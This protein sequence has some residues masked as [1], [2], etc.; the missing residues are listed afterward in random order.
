MSSSHLT[1]AQIQFIDSLADLL[2][3]W[4]LSAHAARLYGY[5]QI[6]NEP[7]SLDDI[8]RDL[9]MSRSH[10]HTAARTLEAHGNAKAITTRGS[11]RIV[12]VCG[13][14]PGTPLRRQV[15]TLGEMSMLISASASSITTGDAARRLA[16]LSVFHKQLQQ[17]MQSV[18]DPDSVPLDTIEPTRS[19]R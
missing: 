17:A 14:D 5:L 2:G 3:N 9:E 7:V 10:A 18:I 16:R 12:Y 19:G 13:E 4:S 15:T 11:K 8:A 6:M 1:P